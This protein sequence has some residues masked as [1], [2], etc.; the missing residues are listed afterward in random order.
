MN[1]QSA[2]QQVHKR[3]GPTHASVGN[4]RPRQSRA[5]GLPY[6]H[7]G[8]SASHGA[9]SS[10]PP[11]LETNNGAQRSSQTGTST[12]VRNED[13]SKHGGQDGVGG[14]DGGS[15]TKPKR[16]QLRSK[17]SLTPDELAE[18]QRRTEQ[19][20]RNRIANIAKRQMEA[21][22]IA[23]RPSVAAGTEAAATPGL[24]GQDI[25]DRDRLAVQQKKAEEV[26]KAQEK[27]KQTQKGKSA[28]QIEFEARKERQEKGKKEREEKRQEG[29][30]KRLEWEDEEK[31]APYYTPMPEAKKGFEDLSTQ[32][33]SRVV[34]FAEKKYV[35]LLINKATC[36]VAGP[37]IYKTG[38]ETDEIFDDEDEDDDEDDE[39]WK[40]DPDQPK[41]PLVPHGYHVGDLMLGLEHDEPTDEAPFG[42]ALKLSFLKDVTKIYD[43]VYEEGIVEKMVMHRGWGELAEDEPG[44]EALFSVAL[45]AVTRPNSMC[46][47]T[48]FP[49]EWIERG[50]LPRPDLHLA[51]SADPTDGNHFWVPEEVC[52]HVNTD[53]SFPLI[54]YG[55]LNRLDYWEGPV[56]G[57]HDQ[58][59]VSYMTMRER[60]EFLLKVIRFAHPEAYDETF[61]KTL[62]KEALARRESTIWELSQVWINENEEFDEEYDYL[63]FWDRE[64]RAEIMKNLILDGLPDGMDMARF[65]FEAFGDMK[66]GEEYNN[67]ERCK[68]CGRRMPINSENDS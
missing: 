19:H 32:L 64:G 47:Y 66:K 49:V 29:R 18:K 31:K 58:Q 7:G 6:G 1:G 15:Q 62:S 3:G 41:G 51:P 28:W 14:G 44:E 25:S 55:T 20:E 67:L 43:R 26:Q 60:S 30:R 52:H 13:G 59:S 2:I 54:C 4:T 12:V 38:L 46:W 42:R 45:A 34:R 63:D 50:L 8:S 10:L 5:Q 65:R 35:F 33:L 27:Q 61:R 21:D 39:S 57:G 23:A 9:W 56:R 48:P 68:S 40:V 11:V 22:K 16:R 53:N 17:A 36:S 37:M 24:S